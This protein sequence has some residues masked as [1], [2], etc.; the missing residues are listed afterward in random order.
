METFAFL[1]DEIDFF[2]AEI[3]WRDVAL[4]EPN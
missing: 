4:V 3:E 2:A 1:Y